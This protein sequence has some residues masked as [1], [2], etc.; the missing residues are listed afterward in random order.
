MK[1][2]KNSYN[3]YAIKWYNEL[4]EF[5]GG[6]SR[7]KWLARGVIIIAIG[8]LVALPLISIDHGDFVMPKIEDVIKHGKIV[9]MLMAAIS[10]LTSGSIMLLLK[11]P[12]VISDKIYRKGGAFKLAKFL[13]LPIA[14]AMVL[15]LMYITG[16]YEELSNYLYL[17]WFVSSVFVWFSVYKV[18]VKGGSI[19]D[20]L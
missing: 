10:I 20:L 8:G 11:L 3:P 12:W 18:R 17:A 2:R 6:E 9:L 7:D 5:T 19:W 13:P 16:I 4:Y 14:V 1:K 15:G